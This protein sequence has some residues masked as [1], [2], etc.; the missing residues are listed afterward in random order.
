[1]KTSFTLFGFLFL[2]SLLV[3][4]GKVEYTYHFG[5]PVLSG[6]GDHQTLSFGK[7]LLTALPGQPLMPYRQVNLILPPGEAA[8]GIEIIFSDEILLPGKFTIAPQQPVQPLSQAKQGMFTKDQTLYST[9]ALFPSDPKG[10]LIT[11][12]LNGRA[13]ALTTFT[14]ARYNPA[15][16]TYSYYSTARVIIRTAPDPKAAQALLNVRPDSRNAALMADNAGM[17]QAYAGMRKA[18]TSDTYE[19]LII[20]PSEFAQSFGA[21]R[22]DYLKQGLRS[23]LVKRD[24]IYSVIPG[25]DQPDKIRNFIIQEY[26]NHGVQYVLLAGDDEQI[27]HRGFY[28]YVQSGSG[29]TDTNIPAD[30]YYSALDGNWN[31]DGDGN[32]AEPGE[33]DLLPDIAVA[34][35]PFSTAGELS[36]ML[37]K[38]HKY[39]FAPIAGEFR[40]ILMAGE[41]LYSNPETWGSD[42][43]ELLKGLKSDNGYTTKGIPEDYPFDYLYDETIY[44]STQDLMAHLNQGRPML[45]HSGH[46]NETYVMKLSNYDI[47]NENFFG[48]NGIDH[49]FTIIYTHGCLCGAFDYND[50]IAEKMVTIDNFAAAF[51]GNSRYGWFNEGQ[52][53]GPSAHLHREFID[54]LY[55]DSLNRIGRAHM[56]SKLMSAAFVTAPGQWE[57]GALRWCFYDCNVLGDPAMAMYGDNPIPLTVNFPSSVLIGSATMNVNVLSGGSPKAGLNCVVIKNGVMVGS[58]ITDAAGSAVISFDPLVQDAGDAQLWVSGYNCTPASFNFAFIAVAG[59]YVV[60][61]FSAVNDPAGNQN[62]LPDFG[63]NILLTNGM[64]NVGGANVNNV[65]VT[66]ST[67]DPYITI[68]DST[69]LYTSVPAGDTVSIVNA[70]AFTVSDTVPDGHQVEF[71]LKAEAGSVWYSGFTLSCFAP[72]LSAGALEINDNAGGNGNGRLDPGETVV[73]TI[74]NYNN[75]GSNS[76]SATGT[77]TTSSP[78]VSLQN[79]QS[80]IGMITTGGQTNAQFTL[81]VD[82]AA[83]AATLVDL[84][85]TVNAGGYHASATYYPAVKLIVEDFESGGFSKFPWASF[86]L[87]PWSVISGDAY[88]GVYCSRSAQISD[89]RQSVMSITLNVLS[90]DSISFWAKVSSEEV[91]DKLQFLTDNQVKGEWSGIQNWKRYSFPVAAGQHTFKWI[92]SKDMSN[93]GGADAAWVDYVIFPGF[94]DYTGTEEHP[95]FTLGLSL[96]PN[97]VSGILTVRASGLQS[98]TYDLRITDAAGKMVQEF[99]DLNSVPGTDTSFRTD[100]SRLKPGSYLCTLTEGGKQTTAS[101]IVK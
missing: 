11:A 59:P 46:A 9:N 66:L 38:T 2:F 18:T 51:V 1:M 22:A 32:W 89:N 95:E 24:S 90:N 10:R 31:T 98:A 85:Y 91:F 73:L 70:F 68:S 61:A 45:N 25:N 49:N 48:L 19:L 79:T 84:D 3:S 39:Q 87:L 20:A 97:P 44:W 64:R 26:Q 81:T 33:D 42:Y 55:S 7:A 65:M 28:C 41:N 50:C 71:S 23:Q 77:L 72:A 43:L 74:P 47:T 67:T 15:T 80:A 34:R 96:S 12:Y 36:H 60:H 5:S 52:T 93:S 53:E 75:G 16:G 99:R 92:Y 63:E 13:M 35:M 6:T 94:V 86:G 58:G 56:E 101:F 8:T 40:K 62:S 30:L 82:P 29:Y 83:P 57:P 27:P 17:D 37:N 76:P 69:E 100:V 88:E 4:A 14:P 21:Y 78:W 54:A